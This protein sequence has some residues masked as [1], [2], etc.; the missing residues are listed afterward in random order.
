[1]L[2]A[3]SIDL[4]YGAAIHDGEMVAEFAGK[5]EILL[6]QQN[7][8]LAERAQIGDGAADILDDRRLDP[9]RRFVQQ[10]HAWAHDQRPADG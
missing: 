4:H 3:Q 1:M 5:V 8:D 2:D 6:D 10:Q 9:L 7:G